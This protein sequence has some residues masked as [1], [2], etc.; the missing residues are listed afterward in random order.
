MALLLCCRG[1][2]ASFLVGQGRGLIVGFVVQNLPN[3]LKKVLFV[4]ALTCIHK[5]NFLKF[6]NNVEMKKKVHLSFPHRLSYFSLTHEFSHLRKTQ[7]D[8]CL[9]FRLEVFCQ[10]RKWGHTFI[11]CLKWHRPSLFSLQVKLNM[12]YRYCERVNPKA[13]LLLSSNIMTFA[14]S[15]EVL[16]L[17]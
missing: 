10:K 4:Y 13:T 3:V 8:I 15:E 11:K 14:F 16:Q 6:K 7:N 17:V 1:A 5:H 9:K 2:R 12:S